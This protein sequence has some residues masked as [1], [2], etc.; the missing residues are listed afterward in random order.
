MS[1]E[2]VMMDP[3]ANS[4]VDVVASGSP[5]STTTISTIAVHSGSTRIVIALLQVR[6]FSRLH[7]R[8][9][10]R[11]CTPFAYFTTIFYLH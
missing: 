4:A 2:P 6:R 3:I 5:A 10:G 11:L 1:N 9:G 8:L 7:S